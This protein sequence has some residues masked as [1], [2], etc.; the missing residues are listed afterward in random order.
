MKPC[1]NSPSPG[2]DLNT[3]SPAYDAKCK[4][5]GRSVPQTA[6]WR[7]EHASPMEQAA[8]RRWKIIKSTQNATVIGKWKRFNHL[9]A[10]SPTPLLRMGTIRRNSTPSYISTILRYAASFKL[11]LLYPGGN[12]PRYTSCKRQLIRGGEEK[13]PA[14]TRHRTAVTKPVDNHVTK[15]KKLCFFRSSS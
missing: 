5:W 7:S 3:G 15:L 2:R 10:K 12:S 4:P 14:L 13:I 6:V 1:Q 11:R 9:Y 8:R